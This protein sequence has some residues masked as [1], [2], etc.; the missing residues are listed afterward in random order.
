MAN[1]LYFRWP[2]DQMA[3]GNT[4][5]NDLSGTGLKST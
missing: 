1:K 2:L 3:A 4:A 5:K